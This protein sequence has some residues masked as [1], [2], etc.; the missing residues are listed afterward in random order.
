MTSIWELV[1]KLSSVSVVLS[2]GVVSL[3]MANTM[4]HIMN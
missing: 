4:A 2:L 1:M 3:A